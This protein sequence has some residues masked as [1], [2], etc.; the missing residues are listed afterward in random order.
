MELI[1]TTTDWN[2]SVSV[3]PYSKTKHYK[4]HMKLVTQAYPN[5][6][7]FS[8]FFIKKI[9]AMVPNTQFNAV[10]ISTPTPS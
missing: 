6:F 8:I 5:F 10:K 4:V 1:Q 9:R 3:S 2:R 7:Y